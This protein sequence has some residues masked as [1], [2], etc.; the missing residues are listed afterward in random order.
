[1]KVKI[2]TVRELRQEQGYKVRVTHYR[3]TSKNSDLYSL[4]DLRDGEFMDFVEAK[5]GKTVVE[6]QSPDGTELKGESI[7]NND[8][9]FCK[10]TGR[11]LA[12]AR[13]LGLYSLFDVRPL[14][15]TVYFSGGSTVGKG[16]IKRHWP[17]IFLDEDGDNLEDSSSYFIEAGKEWYD[18]YSVTADNIFDTFEEAKAHLISK[19]DKI[20]EEALALTEKKEA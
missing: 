16:V 9:A 2:P 18:A 8:D 11:S 7:C 5:G 6:V 20:R 3:K 1:M 17:R 12:L 19:L 13:A 4:A 14:D 15:Q 10:K